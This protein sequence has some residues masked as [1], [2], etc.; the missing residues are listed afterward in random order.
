MNWYKKAIGNRYPVDMR[1]RMPETDKQLY[2]YYHSD[3]P[4]FEKEDYMD[5]TPSAQ[6]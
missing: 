3:D 5:Y 6:L 4:P 2:D 1:R